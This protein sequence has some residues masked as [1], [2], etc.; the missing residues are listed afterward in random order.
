MNPKGTWLYGIPG[1][2]VLG[3]GTDM[4]NFPFF[5]YVICSL[6][7]LYDNSAILSRSSIVQCS[8]ENVM[9]QWIF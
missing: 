5:P 7:L 4:V 3:G 6:A 9:K 2:G 8:T 1:D